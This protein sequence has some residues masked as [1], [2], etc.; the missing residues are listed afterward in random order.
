[1]MLSP[2][3]TMVAPS[4]GEMPWTANAL[5]ALVCG[6]VQGEVVRLPSAQNPTC[7]ALSHD[8]ATRLRKF[9]CV[10][11]GWL[12]GAPIGPLSLGLFI[13]ISNGQSHSF[14]TPTSC[15]WPRWLSG[16]AAAESRIRS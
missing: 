14:N 13:A 10:Q 5:M 8:P 15:P 4:A 1:M 6:A 2:I 11:N 9:A 12:D 7:G 16:G 3:P